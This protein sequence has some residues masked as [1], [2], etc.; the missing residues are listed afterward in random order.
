MIQNFTR[1]VRKIG[2]L[3]DDIKYVN[4][5]IALDKIIELLTNICVLQSEL[6]VGLEYRIECLENAF[7]T[8]NS[9]LAQENNELKRVYDEQIKIIASLDGEIDALK[10]INNDL[11][12]A[13]KLADYTAK[14]KEK[15]HD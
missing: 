12:T 13:L 2:R 5:P 15:N 7:K 10:S 3:L 1:D 8:L 4:S 11:A 6:I 9:D 14:M